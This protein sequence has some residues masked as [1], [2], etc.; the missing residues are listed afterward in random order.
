MDKT[1][2][3]L[4]AEVEALTKQ[5][6]ELTKLFEKNNFSAENV[7][8]KD[9]VHSPTSSIF[10][11]HGFVN[12]AMIATMTIASPSVVTLNNHGFVE[13]QVI[14]F[15]TTG[16]LPTGVTAGTSYYIIATD[17]TTNTFKFSATQGGSAVNTS[18]TQSG[19]HSVNFTLFQTAAIRFPGIGGNLTDGGGIFSVNDV[20]G[21][22][23]YS[24]IDFTHPTGEVGIRLK[25]NGVGSGFRFVELFAGVFSIAL[26]DTDGSGDNYVRSGMKFD[27]SELGT[28]PAFEF[29]ED[30]TAAGTYKGRIPIIVNGVVKYLHYFNA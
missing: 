15:S 17:L 24:E 1:T 27:F 11:Q 6:T 26:V 25:G 21:E 29:A 20:G 10:L 28:D 19:Q 22:T 18:G 30:L 13:D 2:T 16:A 3:Q 12:R 4:S 5:V 9:H 7:F 23:E 14:T 8:T